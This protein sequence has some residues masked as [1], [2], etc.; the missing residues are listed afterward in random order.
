MAVAEYTLVGGSTPDWISDGGYWINPAN[1]KMVG[2]GVDG[3]IPDNTTT[4]T[5]AELQSRQRT[6]HSNY[7]MVKGEQAEG[8]TIDEV[9]AVIKEWVDTR[10]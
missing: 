9:N 2:V 5:L 8:M 7:P 1:K 3:S 4:F 6:I 10:S